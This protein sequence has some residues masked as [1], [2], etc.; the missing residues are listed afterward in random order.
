MSQLI[1]RRGG[2]GIYL[3]D[4]NFGGGRSSVKDLP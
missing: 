4:V 3:V 2:G 1:A